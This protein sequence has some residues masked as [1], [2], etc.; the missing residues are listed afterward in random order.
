MLEIRA[1]QAQAPILS[2]SRLQRLAEPHS[3]FD[4]AL[5]Q[6]GITETAQHGGDLD[7]LGKRIAIGKEGSGTRLLALALLRGH[8]ASAGQPRQTAES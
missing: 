2:R 3:H 7:D 4:I 8:S 5:V 1:H 6:S